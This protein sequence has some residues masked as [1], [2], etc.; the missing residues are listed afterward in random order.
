[1]RVLKARGVEALGHELG[2]HP[3]R[4]ARIE[5][6]PG[7]RGLLGEL[8]DGTGQHALTLGDLGF[9]HALV[10]AQRVRLEDHQR[11]ALPDPSGELGDP[12]A[13]RLRGSCATPGVSAAGVTPGDVVRDHD[14][15]LPLLM[16]GRG[17]LLGGDAVGLRPVPE[18]ARHRRTRDLRADRLCT[19]VRVVLLY[20]LQRGGVGIDIELL[21]RR[22][23][24]EGVGLVGL[25]GL[26]GCRGRG[27][28][29]AGGGHVRAGRLPD[30]AARGECHRQ[31]GGGAYQGSALTDS[32]GCSSIV[33]D[34]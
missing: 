11:R 34:R 28:T 6:G 31:G 25:G 8:A 15:Q 13:V 12:R 9:A 3:S 4:V 17:E 22:G 27:R 10:V 2:L 14:R 5:V 21:A 33:V 26:V 1:M 20:P 32:H 19:G 16:G 18:P 29:V 24:G 23:G 30:R 7:V